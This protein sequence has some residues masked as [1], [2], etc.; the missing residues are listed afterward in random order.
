MCH[1]ASKTITLFQTNDVFCETE[2]Y[3]QCFR[4]KSIKKQDILGDILFQTKMLE[5]CAD[6]APIRANSLLAGRLKYNCWS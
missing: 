1:W 2:K 3:Y 4:F 5:N 6:R